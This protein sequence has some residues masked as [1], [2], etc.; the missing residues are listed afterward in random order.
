M[1]RSSR[2]NKTK[3]NVKPTRNINSDIT[4]NVPSVV[5]LTKNVEPSNWQFIGRELGRI[6]DNKEHF[7]KRLICQCC[8]SWKDIVDGNYDRNNAARQHRQKLPFS[9]HRGD[10]M[11]THLCNSQDTILIFLMGRWISFIFN[12]FQ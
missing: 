2:R 7:G 11:Q 12:L 8:S 1:R 5:K 9:N 3:L 10:I 4:F 6:A